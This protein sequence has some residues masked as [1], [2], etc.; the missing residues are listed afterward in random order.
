MRYVQNKQ[1]IRL[2]LEEPLYVNTETLDI[3]S[4]ELEGYIPSDTMY[5]PFG[6]E[7]LIVENDVYISITDAGYSLTDFI[8]PFSF[9]V[10]NKYIG[11]CYESDYC[12]TGGV[13]Q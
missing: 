4:S 3:S 10:R 1:E 8:I 7:D 13:R 11:E 12:V 6:K 2:E 9:Y 5:L